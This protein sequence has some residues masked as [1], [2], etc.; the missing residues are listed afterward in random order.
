[1]QKIHY[2]ILIYPLSITIVIILNILLNIIIIPDECYYHTHDTNFVFDL[3]FNTSSATNGHPEPTF[4]NLI[5]TIVLGLYIG[6]LGVRFFYKE[7]NS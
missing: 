5:F 2:Q 7:N 4:F 1:M 6:R 3:F